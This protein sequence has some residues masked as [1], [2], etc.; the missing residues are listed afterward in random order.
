MGLHVNKKQL[1]EILGKSERTLTEWQKDGM[2][3][4]H[5]GDRGEANVY[6]TEKC[7]AWWFSRETNRATSLENE[8]AALTR[9]QQEQLTM[10][11]AE[12]R[13]E[14]VNA[15]EIEPTW[16]RF[17]IAARTFALQLR[18]R[19]PEEMEAV[20]SIEAKRDI[21]DGHIETLLRQLVSYDD[22]ESDPQTGAGELCAAGEDDGGGMGAPQARAV[23]QEQRDAGAV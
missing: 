6:D 20:A 16:A 18:W 4:E 22:S 11:I 7:I 8:R 13:G 14:L 5:E 23:G 15:S 17:V 12:V 3:I 21:I 10:K 2:P 1:A 9:L 19:L